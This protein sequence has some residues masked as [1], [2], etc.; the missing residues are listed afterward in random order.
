[1]SSIKPFLEASRL[2][3]GS[4]SEGR[5]RRLKKGILANP[6]PLTNFAL[7]AP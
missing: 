6:A 1:M 7:H 4:A 2:P 3:P 5:L